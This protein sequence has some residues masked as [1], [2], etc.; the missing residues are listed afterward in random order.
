M[1]DPYPR[2]ADETT[3]AIEL[4]V[5]NADETNVEDDGKVSGSEA[6]IDP[7]PGNADETTEANVEIDGKVSNS[8]ATVV[9]YPGNAGK[10]SK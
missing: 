5:E 9:P 8:E 4:S 3:G 6:T 7:Y 2:N 10:K 1:V